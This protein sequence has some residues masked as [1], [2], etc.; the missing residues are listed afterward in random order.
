MVARMFTRRAPPEKSLRHAVIGCLC[1]LPTLCAAALPAPA[2]A[3]AD[4]AASA[5]AGQGTAGKGAAAK[6]AADKASAKPGGKPAKQYQYTIEG[7]C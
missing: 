6:G 3:P 2:S 1:V 7:G 4:K 5:A